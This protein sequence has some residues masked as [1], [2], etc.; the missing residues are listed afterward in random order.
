[1]V[2]RQTI[3]EEMDVHI[4]ELMSVED[5]GTIGMDSLMALSILG[6]LREKGGVTLP[7]DF[8]VEHTSIKAIEKALHITPP[9]AKPKAKSKSK[10]SV[11]VTPAT[12]MSPAPNT[13]LLTPQVDNL[14]KV[15]KPTPPARNATSVLLQGTPKTATK[16][17]FLVPDGGGAPT[18]YVFPS[19]VSPTLAIW[20]LTSPFVKTPEEYIIG[21]PGIATA[22]LREIK[23]RQPT[24]PYNVGGW[25]AGGV[26]SYEVTQQ[27]I[28]G[29]D[30]VDTLVFIDTPCPLIIEPLPG[31]LHRFFGEIGLLGEGDGAIDRLPPWLLPH[32]AASVHALATY[33]ARRLPKGK[34]PMVYTI[35]CED[36]VCKE[37]D[38]PRPDPYPYGH[39]QWLLENRTDFG[40]EPLG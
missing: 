39:A 21:V 7:A 9:D 26:I 11:V 18:S 30:V 38:D 27:L 2:V 8:L 4:S 1:M 17:F 35:W 31:S 20:G 22:F 36:G 10:P 24:G 32:F 13:P 16:T 3:S 25:S 29:G 40:T 34:C 6:I 12:T 23:R 15:K 14:P 33:D 5:L 37:A 19:E 28:A